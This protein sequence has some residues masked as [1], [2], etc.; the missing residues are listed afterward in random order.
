MMEELFI[1]R[2]KNKFDLDQPT[3]PLDNTTTTSTSAIDP[4]LIIGIRDL[5]S[6][7]DRWIIPELKAV[8][9]LVWAVILRARLHTLPDGNDNQYIKKRDVPFGFFRTYLFGGY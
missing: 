9:Q 4:A 8:C 2:K 6:N 3:S 7:D 5:L 1:E